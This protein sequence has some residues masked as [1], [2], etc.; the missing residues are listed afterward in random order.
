MDKIHDVINADDLKDRNITVES[1]DGGL[2]I[3]KVEGKDAGNRGK[4]S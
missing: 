4:D 2:R 1:I 3:I